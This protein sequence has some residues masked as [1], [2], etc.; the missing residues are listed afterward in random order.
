MTF[1]F[2]PTTIDDIAPER[3]PS[4]ALALVP[5]FAVVAF[6]G[7]GSAVL[8]LDPHVPLLWSIVFVGA[9]GIYLGYDWPE[10]SDGVA[11][12]LLMGIQAL[13]IIF[14][15][16]AL[17]ATWVEAGTIPAMMYYGLELLTPSVFL[18]VA[19]ILA[20]VVAFSI[21]SSW[22]TVGTLGVAFVGIGAG[23]GVPAP[24]TVGAVISGAYA[25]D[26]QSP[27]SDTTN[28]AAGVTNT[29][30]YDHIRRMRT[31][32]AVAFGLSV[33]GFAVLG[34]QAAGEIPTDRVVE[35]QTAIAGA[36]DLSVLVFLPL[37]VTF[38][39]ALYG[40]PALPTL[41]AGVFA[42]VITSIAVQGTGF[43]AAWEVFMSGT[44]PETGTDL[45]NDLLATG[46]LTGSAWTITVVVAALS[47]GGLLERTGVLA[48]LAH[49]LSQGVRSSGSLIAGTGA[50]AILVNVL[51]AQQYM[52]IVLPGLT[53]RNLYE[54]FDLDSEELSR[55]VEA[56]GTPTG[57][58]LPWHAGGVF[59][60][61]ATGVPTL[62]Y[63]P[64]YLFGLLSP[65]VLFVMA[66]SGLGV[67]TTSRREQPNYAD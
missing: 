35:I 20:A 18:P 59:M 57:A 10:L 56:A 16:Y 9:F 22:T 4:F 7:V 46:G 38:G 19:A 11:N 54:E 67:P 13:L 42:G 23:L 52:S 41:V 2:T 27:L 49:R 26:K 39:L 37:V 64:F 47:L 65:L 32:T 5:V 45:V 48:V 1:D 63:A 53:L 3:R 31:G 8:G 12:G 17:I 6:L 33:A 60:A 30:L 66:F 43:V 55:A 58:L 14:T 40:Y 21:G 50:S 44:A 25:G 51:T 28:L 36:Y 29:P 15:I 61:S 24:M 34:L 62:E